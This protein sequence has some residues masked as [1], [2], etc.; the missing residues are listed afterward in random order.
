M[1]VQ[2]WTLSEDSGMM[3]SLVQKQPASIRY[4]KIKRYQWLAIPH[5][6]L[7]VV[8]RIMGGTIGSRGVLVQA[9]TLAW[10]G[11]PC[12]LFNAICTTSNNYYD[13]IVPAC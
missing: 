13:R 4:A 6:W 2:A 9:P 7:G 11:L 12:C 5:F 3:L 1:S 10:L 8:L